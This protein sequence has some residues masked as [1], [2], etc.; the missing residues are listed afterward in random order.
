MIVEPEGEGVRV[1][2]P[3]PFAI[4]MSKVRDTVAFVAT[5]TALLAGEVDCKTGTAALEANSGNKKSIK[6]YFHSLCIVG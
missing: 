4:A 5:F 1:I 6:L 2:I 3:E